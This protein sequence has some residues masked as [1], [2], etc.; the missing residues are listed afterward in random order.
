MSVPGGGLRGSVA[1]KE[2]LDTLRQARIAKGLSQAALAREL[3][4][5]PSTIGN[6]EALTREMPLDLAE[7]WAEVCGQRLVIA[8]LDTSDLGPLRHEEKA[9]VRLLREIADPRRARVV[10]ELARSIGRMDQSVLDLV[11]EPL[12]E[13]LGRTSDSRDDEGRARTGLG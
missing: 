3:K 4:V 10:I 6:Y 13:R 9:H 12:V 8:F 1:Y 11:L 2:L 5:A 7:R